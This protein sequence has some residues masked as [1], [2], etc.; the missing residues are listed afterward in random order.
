MLHQN[1]LTKNGNKISSRPLR[2]LILEIINYQFNMLIFCVF[3]KNIEKKGSGPKIIY[4]HYVNCR[5]KRSEPVFLFKR[6]GDVTSIVPLT[7][8]NNYLFDISRWDKSV[9]F[10]EPTINTIL[11]TENTFNLFFDVYERLMKS[12][13]KCIITPHLNHIKSLLL[14][15]QIFIT[16]T[17]INKEPYDIFIFHN[18]HTT[19]NDNKSLECICSYKETDESVCVCLVLCVQCV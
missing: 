5:Y 19:Y 7:A 3:I 12:K 6:E 2:L 9:V 1:N 8:Y 10:D 18:T 15:N 13:F 16:V 14:S 11:I 4:T 17:L